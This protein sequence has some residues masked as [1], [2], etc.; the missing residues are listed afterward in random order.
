MKNKGASKAVV[1]KKQRDDS[2]GV[3]RLYHLPDDPAEQ[4]DVSAEQPQR[5]KEMIT[6]MDEITAGGR[7]RK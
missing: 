6:K 7:T 5:L 3:H 4:K 1:T 2:G